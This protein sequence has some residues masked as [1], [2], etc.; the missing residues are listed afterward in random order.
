MTVT[1]AYY[2]RA[3]V[4]LAEVARSLPVSRYHPVLAQKP[5]F[6]VMMQEFFSI[7]GEFIF[8]ERIVLD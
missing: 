3:L 7:S 4:L 8:R 1:A 6:A 5:F 2:S